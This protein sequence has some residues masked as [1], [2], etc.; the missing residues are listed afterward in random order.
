[1]KK[2][3]ASALIYVLVIALIGGIITSLFLLQF[4]LSLKERDFYLRNY[5]LQSYVDSGIQFVIAAGSSL[6]NNQPFELD[7]IKPEEKLTVTRKQWGIYSLALSKAQIGKSSQQKAVL[8]GSCSMNDKTGIYVANRKHAISVC[9]STHLSGNSYLPEQGI[10]RAYIEGQNYEGAEL[11]YGPLLKSKKEIPKLKTN[12]SETNFAYLN[13]RFDPQDSIV[14]IEELLTDTLS[15]SFFNR[16]LVI[17]SNGNIHLS[18]GLFQGNII[19]YSPKKISID[20]GVITN[21][22]I[23]FAKEIEIQQNNSSNLQAFCT[24]SILLKKESH[25]YFPS[26]L[27]LLNEGDKEAEESKNPE[28]LL[29]ENSRL[30]GSLIALR[31]FYHPKLHL[32]LSL[33]KNALVVGEAYTNDRAQIKGE[34]DGSLYCN[35]LYLKTSSSVYENYLLN[36]KIKG[37][38]RPHGFCGFRIEDTNYKEAIICEVD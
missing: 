17:T 32:T 21:S 12:F 9:G 24:Q 18:S 26:A 20:E 7:I 14:S 31:K 2:L 19:F 28:I 1:M 13:G 37:E 33:D 36:A 34:I 3:K 15:N 35:T 30:N 38:L 25:L 6:E 4:E 10:K 16:T 22:I 11:H 8:I 23:L 5:R 29:E 27:V